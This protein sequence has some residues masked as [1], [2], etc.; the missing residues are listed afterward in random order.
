MSRGSIS[1]EACIGIFVFFIA[2]SLLFAFIYGYILEA[3]AF[4]HFT[5]HI[6]RENDEPIAPADLNAAISSQYVHVSE[7]FEVKSLAAKEF[8]EATASG[9]YNASDYVVFVTDTGKCYH[10]PFC[11]TVSLSLHPILLKDAGGYTP[12]SVCYPKK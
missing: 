12:C 6:L 9:F 1:A 7:S 2:V 11:R 3:K 4:D 10:K 8:I 5:E